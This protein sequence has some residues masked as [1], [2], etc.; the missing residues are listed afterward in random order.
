MIRA[1]QPHPLHIAHPAASRQHRSGLSEHATVAVANRLNVV[2]I[3][4]GSFLC[5]CPAIESP[6]M[7]L[8]RFV[9]FILIVM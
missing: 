6:S 1:I 5:R 9:H 4:N 8:L 2:L 3:R 7:R